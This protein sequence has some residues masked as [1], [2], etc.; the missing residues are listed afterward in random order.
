MNIR[1]NKAGNGSQCS[2]NGNVSLTP[3]L[4]IKAPP[5]TLPQR[6][7]WVRAAHLGR[8]FEEVGSGAQGLAS[9]QAVANH[10]QRAQSRDR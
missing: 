1:A 7:M 5:P 9:P 8:Q 6:G 3:A 2:E 10:A 4:N